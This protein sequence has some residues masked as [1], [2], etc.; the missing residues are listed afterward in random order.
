[1]MPGGHYVRL[2]RASRALSWLLA[3]M[4]STSAAVVSILA[5]LLLLVGYSEWRCQNRLFPTHFASFVL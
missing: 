2:R 3:A 4:T 5:I 1:M